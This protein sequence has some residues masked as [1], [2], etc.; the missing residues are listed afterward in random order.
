MLQLVDEMEFDLMGF[1]LDCEAV[2]GV[3]AFLI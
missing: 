3:R 1:E 2:L